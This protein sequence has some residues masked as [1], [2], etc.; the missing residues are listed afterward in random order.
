VTGIGTEEAVL[1]VARRHVKA[2][3][4]HL[5]LGQLVGAVM[6]LFGNDNF[7]FFHA[8]LLLAGGLLFLAYGAGLALLPQ[9]LGDPARVHG[10]LA[11]LQFHMAL[12]GLWGMLAGS[13]LPVGYGLDRLAVPFGFVAAAAAALYA[14]VL[15]KAIG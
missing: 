1:R 14:A 13:F 10:G 11:N 15:W 2:G 6:I 8:H 9:R 12:G 4:L 3:L 5:A 7:Q